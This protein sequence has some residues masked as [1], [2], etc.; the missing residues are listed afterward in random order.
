MNRM[1]LLFLIG[2]HRQLSEKV[3]IAIYGYFGVQAIAALQRARVLCASLP[4]G[5]SMN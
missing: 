5:G 1:R 4:F 3:Q 2:V